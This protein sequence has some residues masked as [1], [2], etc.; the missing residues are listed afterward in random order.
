MEDVMKKNKFEKL[1]N[2]PDFIKPNSQRLDFLKKS[3]GGWNSQKSQ[4][5]DKDIGEMIGQLIV[6]LG[7]LSL[8]TI[9]QYFMDLIL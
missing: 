5:R 9:L 7:L 4:H 6:G 1:N 8:A 2:L 3:D